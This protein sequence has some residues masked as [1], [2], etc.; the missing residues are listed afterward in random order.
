M[1]AVIALSISFALLTRRI[2][3]KSGSSH[4]RS[5]LFSNKK[6]NV[7]DCLSSAAMVSVFYLNITS[8]GQE[9]DESGCVRLNSF[10]GNPCWHS[11]LVPAHTA[12]A[13][14]SPC[15]FVSCC[16]VSVMSGFQPGALP[17]G[18]S[19]THTLTHVH[20]PGLNPVGP[21]FWCVCTGLVGMQC[22]CCRAGHGSLLFHGDCTQ[23]AHSRSSQKHT[24]CHSP[25]TPKLGQ[26][27]N[28]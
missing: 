8:A 15:W 3:T 19:A 4:V 17:T 22:L 6:T 9:T 5:R 18:N 16:P 10:V 1:K 13:A 24:F 2:S 21:D 20:P 25:D 7:F 28:T 27:V 14:Q 12:D 11:V 26:S 23:S